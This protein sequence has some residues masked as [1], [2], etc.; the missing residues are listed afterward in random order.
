MNRL[1]SLQYMYLVGHAVYVTTRMACYEFVY[2]IPSSTKTN[3]MISEPME[4]QPRG[5]A[6]T[7]GTVQSR[8]QFVAC[9]SGGGVETIF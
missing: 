3:K 7:Q 2:P 5:A 8:R 1:D 9:H 4:L 6:L